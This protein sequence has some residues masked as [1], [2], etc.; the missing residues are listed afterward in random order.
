VEVAR[1][2]VGEDV[3]EMGSTCPGLGPMMGPAHGLTAGAAVAIAGYLVVRRKLVREQKVAS[4]RLGRL[5]DAE[6]WRLDRAERACA[7]RGGLARSG[8]ARATCASSAD[9]ILKRGAE[10][11]QA[12]LVANLHA[13]GVEELYISNDVDGTDPRWVAATGTMVRGGMTP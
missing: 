11:I 6:A 2:G 1:H 8:S 4:G 5:M 9:G 12:E 3:L 7:S 13:A 10:V